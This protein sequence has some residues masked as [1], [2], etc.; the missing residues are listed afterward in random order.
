M[1]RERTAG[2]WWGWAGR[3]GARVPEELIEVSV[4]HVLKDHDEGVPIATHPIELDNVFVLQV[5][6]QLSL[7]L[8]ILPGSQ[9]GVLQ[10]LETTQ[11]R[12]FSHR[13]PP[14]KRHGAQNEE[15]AESQQIGF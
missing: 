2:V 13:S 3:T 7:P 10:G 6:E 12:S 4:L 9:G 1:T 14:G 11:D 15:T 8:E 5:G